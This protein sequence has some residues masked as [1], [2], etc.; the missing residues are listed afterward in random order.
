MPPKNQVSKLNTKFC[1]ICMSG[2]DV[3]IHP[4][5]LKLLFVCFLLLF[6]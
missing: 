2:A 5:L 6:V 4:F 3:N 1:Y